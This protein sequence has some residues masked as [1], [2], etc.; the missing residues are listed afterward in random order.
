MQMNDDGI[1]TYLITNTAHVTE[2]PYRKINSNSGAY[3]RS[4]TLSPTNAPEN[5]LRINSA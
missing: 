1:K 3:A 4:Y 5:G 2:S